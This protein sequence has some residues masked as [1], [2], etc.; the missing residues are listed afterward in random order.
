VKLP[1]VWIPEAD[2]DLKEAF[3]WYESLH[4]D[5][6]MRFAQAVEAAVEVITRSP[7]AFQIE[8]SEIRRVGV[9]RFP[10]SFLQ[11]RK[12]SG[13]GHRLHAWKTQS[14]TVETSAR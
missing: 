12:Q 4:P 13:C 14:E 7:L 6:G 2:A 3:A 5:L 1:V 9:R 11:G 10:R 8:H